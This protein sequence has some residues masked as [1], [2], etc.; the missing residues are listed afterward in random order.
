MKRITLA[1]GAL[2]LGPTA[3]AQDFSIG[4]FN[5]YWAYDD[6]EPHLNWRERR[7]DETYQET[8][9]ELADAILEIDVD[10]LALQEVENAKVVNDLIDV[11][12]AKGSDYPYVFVGQGLDAFTGQD[13]AIISKYPAVI[14]PVLRYPLA[15]EDYQDDRN[16]SPRVAALPKFMRV[17]F[18]IEGTIVT[19]F[20]AHLK[21]QRGGETAE[22]ERLAQARLV[23]R[24]VRA[25]S[26]KGDSRSPSY[27]ALVGDLNDDV[28]TPTLRALR[29]LHDGSFNFQQ[30]TRSINP[31]S[32][33]YTHIYC[34]ARRQDGTCQPGRE[35]R[36][37][38]DHVLASYFLDQAATEASIVR[39][40]DDVSDHDAVRVEFS[41]QRGD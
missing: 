31:E 3:T 16:G 24:I 12:R 29:G 6:E 25:V 23:R 27:V 30:T 34:P 9:D 7:G 4:T 15:L 41:I 22:E 2:L 13:V 38:L 40:D 8:L 39:I 5:T 17:D 11:L 32:E 10:I 20:A 18:S 1:L 21:S 14:E 37:Q 33:R 19:V 28:D 36:E 35:E 26:E